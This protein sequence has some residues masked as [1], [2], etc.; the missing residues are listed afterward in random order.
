MIPS[1]TTVKQINKFENVAPQLL[2]S[3]YRGDTLGCFKDPQRTPPTCQMHGRQPRLFPRVD[4]DQLVVGAVYVVE[5]N[6]KKN[7]QLYPAAMPLSRLGSSLHL[8]INCVLKYK[9]KANNSSCSIVYPQITTVT[10]P[11]IM[12]TKSNYIFHYI[13]A[14][15]RQECNKFAGPI[16]A[17]LRPGN[18]APLEEMLQRWRVVGNT[19]SDLTGPR[20]E[21]Q[22]FRSRDERVTARTTG[23]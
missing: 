1:K 22:I 7:Y 20:F 3:C 15:L 8:K 4:D 16:S 19:V 18:T 10:G 2:P 17:S 23:R 11:E 12:S 21:P 13:L 9:R 6:C 14:A 5:V